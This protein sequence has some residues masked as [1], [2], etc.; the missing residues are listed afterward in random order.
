MIP[1][2]NI[3]P[4]CSH[5]SSDEDEKSSEERKSLREDEKS[6]CFQS[7]TAGEKDVRNKDDE[8]VIEKMVSSHAAQPK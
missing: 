1:I 8:N 7:V 5:S 6:S 2:K 4:L 3:S